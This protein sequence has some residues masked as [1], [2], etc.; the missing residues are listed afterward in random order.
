MY[1]YNVW[2]EAWKNLLQCLHKFLI[3]HCKYET[4]IKVWSEW[5][6]Q[7]TVMQVVFTEHKNSGL[8]EYMLED[9]WESIFVVTDLSKAL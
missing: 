8:L 5:F 3:I 2:K 9:L 1:F 6:N 4:V 7:T